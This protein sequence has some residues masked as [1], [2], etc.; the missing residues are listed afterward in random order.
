LIE[1]GG[2]APLWQ[3]A[4]SLDNSHL[5]GYLLCMSEYTVAEARDNFT[6]LIDRALAGE[7]VTI[8]RRGKPVVSIV[9]KGPV[10]GLTVDLE[11]LDRVRVTPSGP[12]ADWTPLVELMRRDEPY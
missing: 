6:K 11:W 9:P 10:R 8:T 1:G 7:E 5:G 2:H 3:I 12:T 4:A